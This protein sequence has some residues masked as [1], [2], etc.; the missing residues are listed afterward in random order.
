MTFSNPE[1][2]SQPVLGPISNVLYLEDSNNL[3]AIVIDSSND[4]TFTFTADPEIYP[5]SCTVK[6]NNLSAFQPRL[7]E[8]FN[9]NKLVSITYAN[10]NIVS[11]VV[12]NQ[13]QVIPRNGNGPVCC[14]PGYCPP[15]R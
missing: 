11:L 14:I 8:A 10:D 7:Q 9:Y 12:I 15:C 6:V 5:E 13:V 1:I 4:N 3:A 2:N